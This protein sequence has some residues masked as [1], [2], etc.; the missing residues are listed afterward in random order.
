MKNRC[1]LSESADPRTAARRRQVAMFARRTL[2][3]AH[4]I[5]WHDVLHYVHFQAQ[6]PKIGIWERQRAAPHGAC[7]RGHFAYDPRGVHFLGKCH[8]TDDQSVRIIEDS[9]PIWLRAPAQRFGWSSV[10]NPHLVLGIVKGYDRGWFFS[11][12][13]IDSEGWSD[14]FLR[15]AC[16]DSR[17]S[18]GKDVNIF[19]C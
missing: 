10:F 9:V 4:S 19:H 18:G 8:S 2:R 13:E 7:E 15:K 17:I 6:R 5:G 11:L 16:D 1:C 3:S 14:V 12:S